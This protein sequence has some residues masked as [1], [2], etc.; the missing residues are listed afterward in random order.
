MSE[1]AQFWIVVIFF[2][3]VGIVML[4][5]RF[6]LASSM[7]EFHDAL[8]DHNTE[9]AKNA[10][11]TIKDINLVEP[12]SGWTI[13][14]SAALYG[15]PEIISILVERGANV[16][17]AS[18]AKGETPLHVAVMMGKVPAVKALLELGADPNARAHSGKT[19]IF[20]TEY[21]DKNYKEIIE[22]LVSKGANINALDKDGYNPLFLAMCQ[23]I[24]LED[25]E[26]FTPEDVKTVTSSYD[27]A[28]KTFS[29]VKKVVYAKERIESLITAGADINFHSEYEGMTPL[30]IACMAG[31]DGIAKMLCEKGA[32][33]NDTDDRGETALMQACTKKYPKIVSLLIEKGCN[34]NTKNNDGKTALEI[35]KEK[36]YKDIIEILK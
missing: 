21:T 28:L 4:V 7:R 29:H 12:K 30:M 32:N 19:P 17:H 9:R 5:K 23:A 16:N 25:E 35:A 13:L 34:K 3:V 1:N 18:F 27:L 31:W 11:Q 36:G 2:A 26:P 15:D 8:K 10:L 6:K 22:L 14:F 24:R 20:Y 33:I